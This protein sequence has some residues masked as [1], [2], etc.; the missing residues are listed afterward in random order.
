MTI[1]IDFSGII[2]SFI[3]LKNLL[4]YSV[5]VTGLMSVTIATEEIRTEVSKQGV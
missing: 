4:I 3:I 2:S 5:T 1:V